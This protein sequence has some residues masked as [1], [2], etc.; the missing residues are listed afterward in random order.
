MKVQF[1]NRYQKRRFEEILDEVLV[2]QTEPISW[3]IDQ[4]IK[5]LINRSRLDRPIS[6]MGSNF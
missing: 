5:R 6:V 3:P 1:W 4:P 2:W